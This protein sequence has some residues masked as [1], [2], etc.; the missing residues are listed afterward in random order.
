MNVLCVSVVLHTLSRQI[1]GSMTIADRGVLWQGRGFADA[2]VRRRSLVGL[3]IAAC[4]PFI[5]EGARAQER[6]TQVQW[7]GVSTAGQFVQLP[8]LM[9]TLNA[10]LTQDSNFLPAF[11]ERVTQAVTQVANGHPAIEIVVE[12]L[13][14]Q[15]DDAY[16]LSLVLAGE[17]IEPIR[18]FVCEAYHDPKEHVCR[19]R[20]S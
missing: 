9:P 4:A 17:S 6:K 13:I 8:M 12:D 11:K 10:V 2:Y 15:S 7:A 19:A 16:V 14:R 1:V 3:A 20:R 5:G 18:N